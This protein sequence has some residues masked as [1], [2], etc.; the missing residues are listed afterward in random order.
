MALLCM[1]LAIEP[2][3]M[4]PV[5]MTRLAIVS[6]SGPRALEGHRVT[7]G[8]DQQVACSRPLHPAADRRVEHRD[9]L[10]GEHCV[11]AA[12]QGRRVGRV[13]DIERAGLELRDDAV[14]AEADRLHL[15]RPGQAGRDDVGDR[16]EGCDSRGPGG[17]GGDQGFGRFAPQIVDGDGVSGP[18]ELAGNRRADIADS[19]EP[20]F[21]EAFLHL[22]LPDKE[23]P[24]VSLSE[25]SL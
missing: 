10:R 7:A 20:E 22:C 21:H 15:G 14:G 24:C 18:Q 6:S 3:P 1:I 4:P 2:V 19:D 17:A 9:T 12:D 11:D 25:A 16:R 23:S 5:Y 13:V 8:H